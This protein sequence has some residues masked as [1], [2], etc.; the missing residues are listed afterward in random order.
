GSRFHRAERAAQ[1]PSRCRI[2]REGRGPQVAGVS[3]CVYALASR[4]PSRMSVRGVAGERLRAIRISGITAI[5][6][7]MKRAPTATIRNLK[8]HSAVIDALTRLV[9]A[10]LPTRFATC[11]PGDE[12]LAAA[13]K[14]RAPMLKARLRAVRRRAQMTIRLIAPVV[15][16]RRPKSGTEYLRQ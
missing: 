11:V 7:D 5:V 10:I 14:A 15:A 2:G 9:D 12:E 6:G 3:V 16:Q 13:V 1:A 4:T 8:R